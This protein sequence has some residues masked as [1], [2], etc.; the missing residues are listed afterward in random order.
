[1]TSEPTSTP[2]MSDRGNFKL[3]TVLAVSAVF[4]GA[5]NL[6]AYITAPSLFEVDPARGPFTIAKNYELTR[7]YGRAIETY[8]QVA[9]K[10]PNSKYYD[11]ARIGAANSL[12]ALG[13][14][15]EAITE[16]ERILP[17]L[18]Q[19][20]ALKAKRLI[21]L[22]KLARAFEENRNTAKFGAVFDL[23]SRE[24]PD[25]QATQDAKRYSDIIK[26]AENQLGTIGANTS[27]LISVLVGEAEVS[28]PFNVNVTVK[29]DAVPA[30]PFSIAFN[31]SFIAQFEFLSVVPKSV[32]TQDYWDKRFFQFS[33]EERDP[34]K[35][36]FTFRSEVPGKHI[37]D[38]DL[39]SNFSL[40][41]MNQIHTI[42]V[43]GN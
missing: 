16:Y 4:F 43:T 37:L 27:E 28:Q 29:A 9:R 21:V 42:E 36:V 39:E 22:S 19:D 1:M 13:R 34:T 7:V 35:F 6:T 3:S 14:R 2:N 38:I 8:Q 32:G 10:F 26:S 24:F 40:I 5:I 17:T 31:S 41:E 15:D 23:L 30:G 11:D 20:E 12:L 18:V 25:S 33:A